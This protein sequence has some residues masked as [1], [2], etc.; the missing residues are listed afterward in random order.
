MKLGKIGAILLAVWLILQGLQQFV[1]I[2]FLT[3][4]IMAIL[5]LA[6]GIILLIGK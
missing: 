6:T 5:A 2:S 1:N 4:D 3:G